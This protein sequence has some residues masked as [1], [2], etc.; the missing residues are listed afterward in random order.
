MLYKKMLRDFQQHFGQFLSIFLLSLL[1]VWLFTG[2]IGEVAGVTSTRN[3][4]H[5]QTNLADGWIYGENF[6][7]AQVDAIASL[8]DVKDVQ[9][10]IYT[11]G[12]SENDSTLFLYF[13][14]ED[15]VNQPLVLE[16][17]PFDVQ[18]TGS[19]WIAQRFAIEQNISLGDDYTV[20]IDENTSYTLQVAGF[21]WNPE[22]E[23]Y[24]DEIDLEPDYHST[25]YA[26]ASSY[27]LETQNYNQIIFTSSSD[28][29]SA[30]EEEIQE[31]LGENYSILLGR[32]GIT[33]LTVLDD[34]IQQHKMMAILFP[35]F[36][37]IIAMLTTITT[38]KRIVDRQRTQIGTLKAIGMKKSKIY[39]HYLSYGFFPS[40]TGALLGTVIG[41]VTLAPMLFKMKYYLDSSDEYM[42]PH[43]DIVYPFY[44]WILGIAIVIL[45]TA[46]TWM[47]CREIL[48]LPPAVAL[49]PAQPKSAKKTI[50]EKLPFW[51]QLNFSNRYNLRDIARNKART[52]FGFA[53]T[54]SCMALMLCGFE[55][56]DNFQNAVTDLYANKLMN[57]SAMVT[58]STDIPIKEAERLRNLV[59]G[60]LIMSVTTEIRL[61][62]STEKYSYH[63]NVYEQGQIANVLDENMNPAKITGTDFTVTKKTADTI[64]I[65]IGDTIEWHIYGSSH[66][67]SSTVTAIIRAPF[68]QGIV[69][70]REAIEQ[71]NCTFTPTR[72]LTQQDVN[73]S[74][75]SESSYID[76]VVS[77]SGMAEMLSNYLE[78]VN[79]VMGFML[80]L[81]IVLAVIVLY[82]LGLLSFEERLKEMAT[83]KVLG[84]GTKKLRGLMLQQ[85]IILS[86][87]GAAIGIPIGN[88]MLKLLV[89]SLGNAM[90]IPS[91]GNILY[92]CISFIIT[93]LVS[94]I[95]NL[96]FTKKIRNM[97]MVEEIK[98]ME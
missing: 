4:Y 80:A 50:F 45:C 78:L 42:L 15:T 37:V 12:K 8:K 55:A 83:L 31:I 7:N 35:S 81:A 52:I 34:E 62:D 26:F 61:P 13:E 49:R 54:V 22:Y 85:N 18:D 60:E 72:L 20:Y 5:N 98:N 51:N 86:V 73:I 66:W 24:K 46:A 69:T 84:F 33:N 47:S 94:V 68:E 29:I 56:K 77:K 32:D 30:F 70:T 71:A 6:T 58:L 44:F 3:L 57:Q 91:F 79:L 21:I 96:L 25:G 67:I 95:V 40:L 11:Q 89:N 92:I 87:L 93:I 43:F 2:V 1:A 36:F 64:G 19:I 38:M 90:D 63:M 75:K 16:G 27:V 76:T 48:Q 17:K 88:M 10:R 39:L 9:K 65:S 82:S 74:L 41:P 59:N 97:N 28:N 14:D 53:G 23:Y